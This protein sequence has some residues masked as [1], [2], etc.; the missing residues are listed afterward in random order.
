MLATIWDVLV[1]WRTALLGFIFAAAAALP[2]LINAP[3][4]L[5]IIPGEYRPYVIALAFFLMYLTRPRPAVRADDY[6]ASV[7]RA[8]TGK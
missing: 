2:A 5:A 3:E 1:R 4:V 7:S 6:E 8:R